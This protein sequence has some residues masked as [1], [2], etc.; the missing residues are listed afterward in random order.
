VEQGDFYAPDQLDVFVMNANGSGQRVLAG[1]PST[2]ESNPQW[3]PDGTKIAFQTE[4]CC[5]D[6]FDPDI[7]VINPDRTGLINVTG[8]PTADFQFAWKP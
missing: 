2:S 7:M 3:S 4:D 6:K 1:D 8:D 5:N